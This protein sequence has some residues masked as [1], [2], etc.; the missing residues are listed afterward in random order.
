MY[1]QNRVKTH[2][3]ISHFLFLISLISL[4]SFSAL[5]KTQRPNFIIIFADDLGMGDVGAFY[6]TPIRTPHI[7]ALAKSG[8]KFTSFYSVSP[9]CSPSR[10]GLLTGR[11]PIRE[12][13]DGVV[14]WPSSFT[15]MPEAELT[16]AELLR[17]KGYTSKIVGK[18]HLGHVKR[19]LPTFQG[20]DEF[21]GVPYSNDMDSF[22]L[23]DDEDVINFS[24]DQ[25][26]LT[27]HY[28]QSSIEFITRNKDRPF[29]LYLSH[30]MPHVP[31]YA[32]EEFAGKSK[33]GIYGDTIEELDWS[34]GQITQTLKK[35]KLDKKTLVIFSSDNGPWLDMGKYGGSSGHFRNGKFTTFEGGVRVPTI[36]SF[37][38]KIKKNSTYK[39]AASM[40][41]WFPTI[42][43]YA[44]IS[45]PNKIDGISITS[46]LHGK[47]EDPRRVIPYFEQ[48]KV[49]GIRVGE[50]KLKLPHKGR[51][52]S[53]AGKWPGAYG[54]HGELLYNLAKDPGEKNNLASE[55]PEKVSELKKETE[56]FIKKLG[57]V[58]DRIPSRSKADRYTLEWKLKEIEK[59]KK[60]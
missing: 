33:L 4:I 11:Y 26:L 15:G 27:K 41:D 16:I 54:P 49:T 53:L 31:L 18:W 37:P 13:A 3:R 46:V 57:P 44:G 55:M 12:G 39:Y 48:G 32:S 28:T 22:V 20:F 24:P 58:K 17:P 45:P 23:M 9:V 21:F 36:A 34:V 56:A 60:Q 42:A 35:L 29:F 6:D 30:T 14:F 52:Q 19:Y 8:M 40:L 10:F 59:L 38:G 25:R 43:E 51:A 1:F 7:D 2:L 5:A 47:S 50:W